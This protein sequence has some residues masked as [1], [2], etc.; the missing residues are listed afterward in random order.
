[1]E[2]TTSPLAGL[3]RMD[4]YQ[5]RT[6]HLFPGVESVRWYVRQHREELARSQALLI[7]SGRTWIDAPKF[8]ACVMQIAAGATA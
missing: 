5:R 6:S 1:M 7:I 4:A 8:D 3:M 2:V